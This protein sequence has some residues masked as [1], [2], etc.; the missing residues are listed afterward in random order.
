MP[1]SAVWRSESGTDRYVAEQELIDF[2]RAL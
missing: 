2:L 1:K